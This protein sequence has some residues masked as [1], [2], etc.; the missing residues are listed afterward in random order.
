[1]HERYGQRQGAGHKEPTHL[2]IRW[3]R[4]FCEVGHLHNVP[5]RTGSLDAYSPLCCIRK[6]ERALERLVR[7]SEVHLWHGGRGRVGEAGGE[8]RVGDVEIMF[9]SAVRIALGWTTVPVLWTRQTRLVGESGTGRRGGRTYGEAEER[10]PLDFVR[11]GP[12]AGTFMRSSR[13]AIVAGGTERRRA[14]R[15]ERERGGSACLA[16]A[17]S[18]LSWRDS[19]CDSRSHWLR[20]DFKRRSQSNALAYVLLLPAIPRSRLDF[21]AHFLFPI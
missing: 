13:E 7:A 3:S 17:S 1:M 11:T 2:D 5:P 14:G 19:S 8:R 9:P 16:R 21:V 4:A 6:S 12:P 10:A 15:Q 18:R 20:L